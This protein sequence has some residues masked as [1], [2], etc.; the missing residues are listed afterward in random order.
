MDNKETNK[1]LILVLIAILALCGCMIISCCAAAVYSM[2]RMNRDTIIEFLSNGTETLPSLNDPD[3]SSGMQSEEE[4]Q[5]AEGLTSE[6]QK[7]ISITEEI[8]GITAENKLAP[9][10]KSSDELRQD[11][12]SDLQEVTDEEFAE[13]LGLYKILG[14]APDDFDL[15]QF[16]VDLYTEQIAGFYDP[17]ENAM[18]L[19]ADISPRENALTLAHEY[20]HYL[21]YNHDEFRETLDYDDD[22]CE[23]NGE[24]C[25]IIDALVEGDAS[26]TENLADAEDTI[27]K[28]PDNYTNNE[29]PSSTVFDNAPKFFQDSLLFPYV[30]GFDFVAYHYMR[31]G[32]EAVNRM[33]TNL[34][35]SVEQ[36]M[37]PEKY[38]IDQPVSVTL[39]PFR[40]MITKNFNI[41]Q[42]DVLNEA[43]I[44]QILGSGW[45]S[46]WQLS[47]KQAAAG[48]DGWGGGAYIFAEAD[49]QPLFFSKT[50]WDS[51]KEADEAEDA[52]QN[53]CNKRFGKQTSENIWQSSDGSSV[54]LIKQND[55]LYW[56]ILPENC[57]A[58][59]LV[60][61]IRNGSAL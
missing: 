38:L 26:L 51:K 49:D 60:G 28:L 11:L 25:V 27:L 55:I 9:I 47:E 16:Y 37:H 13:E 57:D 52:F 6:E 17:E 53:Y 8:R 29:E 2:S 5:T 3:T 58:A 33:Y 59:T 61:L 21:Q 20:T 56:M 23:K 30:Y 45:D 46:D 48:A 32:F 14:F 19:I 39:E 36:I 4:V 7:I 34:P 50:I 40:S 12:I 22:F 35:Q 15:R 1:T 42:E 54:Y 41:I 44:L 18:Y 24:M 10:Y 43:D 31:G